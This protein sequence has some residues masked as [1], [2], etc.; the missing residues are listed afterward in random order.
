MCAD[1]CNHQ[2]H[3]DA[4]HSQACSFSRALA[5]SA[6]PKGTR[7]SG[8]DRLMSPCLFLSFESL[9]SSCLSAF[10]SDV[11]PS[12]SRLRLVGL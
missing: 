5:L 2:A 11:F 9:G 6:A 7:S 3:Q 1:S 12:A 8:L 4:E 10:V